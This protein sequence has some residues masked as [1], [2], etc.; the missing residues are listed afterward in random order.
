[1]QPFV[2]GLR[3]R[4]YFDIAL[5]Y[6]DQ[7]EQ[8]STLSQETRELIPFERVKRCSP[9]PAIRTAPTHSGNSWMPPRRPFSCFSK[10][11]PNHPLAAQAN[12]WRGRILF[13]K[14]PRGDLRVRRPQSQF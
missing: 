13:E 9:V 12:T 6:L 4:G 3:D 8:K 14:A 5:Q 2:Q 1:M 11:S 10:A 7:L